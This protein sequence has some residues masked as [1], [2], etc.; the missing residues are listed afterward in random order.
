MVRQSKLSDCLI[1]ED[2]QVPLLRRLKVGMIWYVLCCI[3]NVQSTVVVR[4][5]SV[6]VCL[7]WYV[8]CCELL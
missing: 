3:S 4:C 6:Y 5:V 8:Q 7:Y 1:L 2:A